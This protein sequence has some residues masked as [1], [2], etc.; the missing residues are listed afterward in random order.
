MTVTASV[1]RVNK[2]SKKFAKSI[3]QSMLYGV[4]DI[5][6]SFLNM[7]VDSEKLR[8]GEFWAVDLID[9]TLA[10]GE[11]LGIIGSNGSGKSTLL[12]MLNGIF[13]PDKGSIEI[14]GR[15]G[16]LI[17]VGAGFHPVLTGKEN[18]YINGAILGMDRKEIDR[19]FGRI[20][21]FA[22]IGDFLDTPVKNYS[23]GMRVRL[24]FSIAIHSHPD[25]LLIDE[26]L[27]V[28]DAKFQEKSLNK[29][30]Q[31]KSNGTSIVLVSHSITKIL[32]LTDRVLVMDKSKQKAC[33]V[34]HR[35]RHARACVV[36]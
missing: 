23:S 29:I 15:T 5:C 35:F 30:K 27:A 31:L 32:T 12:K 4:I 3:K 26:V 9:F 1:L 2:I 20:V 11:V 33:D 34:F 16:A 18:I 21:E 19:N 17:E 24:G 6:K 28:G 36:M 7:T 14:Y 25:I 22:D 10:K 13:Y 8:T